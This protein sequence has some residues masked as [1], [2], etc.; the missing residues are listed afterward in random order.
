MTLFPKARARILELLAGGPMFGLDMVAASPGVLKR[1]TIY[2]IL[3]RMEDEGL[4]TSKLRPF[5]EM[6]PRRLYSLKQGRGK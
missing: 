6:A 4:V 1:G 5:P 2:V 3:D